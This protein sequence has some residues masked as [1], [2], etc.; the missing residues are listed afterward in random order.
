MRGSN[1]YFAPTVKN[2][3]RYLLP[4]DGRR[5]VDGDRLPSEQAADDSYQA[6]SADLPERRTSV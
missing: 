1:D 4:D 6:V 5:S 2:P 3:G